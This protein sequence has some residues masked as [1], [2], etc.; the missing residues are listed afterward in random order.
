[1]YSDTI[2]DHFRSP[3]NVGPL[4]RPDAMGVAGTPGEGNFMVIELRLCGGII[5]AARF[6]TY[7][8]PGAVASGSCLAEWVSGMPVSEAAGITAEQLDS[9]LD[10]LPLGK[11][12][13]A[14]LAVAA[15]QE[16]LSEAAG[17]GQAERD[18][19]GTEAEE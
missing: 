11:G 18:T 15:L 3:R 19:R 4:E 7:G 16:A 1:M 6:Q 5:D 2:I 12:Y 9:R 14:A 13:C 10:G 8:C 17:T